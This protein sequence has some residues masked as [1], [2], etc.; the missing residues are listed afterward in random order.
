MKKER[1]HNY[2]SQGKY[3]FKFHFWRI[4][5]SAFCLFYDIFLDNSYSIHLSFFEVIIPNKGIVSMTLEMFLCFCC[6][7]S[8]VCR[9]SIRFL[10]ITQ[11]LHHILFSSSSSVMID[12]IIMQNPFMLPSLIFCCLLSFYQKQPSRYVP[13]K[14]H[15]GM[16]VLL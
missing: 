3:I 1:S 14:R 13:R 9:V 12:L 11:Q 2:F 6:F 5:L 4:F 7:R 16:G 15:F 8:I 10:F